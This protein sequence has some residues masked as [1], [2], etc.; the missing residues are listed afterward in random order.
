MYLHEPKVV[1]LPERVPV[2][3]V[4]QTAFVDEDGLVNFRPDIYGHD[5][6]QIKA[7]Q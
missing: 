2:Q 7:I 1:Y 4:Y 5:S 3:F 6:V